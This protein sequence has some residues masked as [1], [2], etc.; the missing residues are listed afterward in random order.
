M[1]SFHLLSLLTWTSSDVE[2]ES[3]SWS[4]IKERS[5]SSDTFSFTS[6]QLTSR[7]MQNIG[8]IHNL[9]IISQSENSYVVTRSLCICILLHQNLTCL[10]L[11]TSTVASKVRQI[12]HNFWCQRFDFN[13][14]TAVFG[15]HLPQCC[16]TAKC[17]WL[18]AF[19]Q[20]QTCA[21]AKQFQFHPHWKENWLGVYSAFKEIYSC[22]TSA[23][24]RNHSYSTLTRR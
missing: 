3:F 2:I 21:I 23:G 16:V 19:Y 6:E 10:I 15:C 4:R 5:K 17:K 20:L 8:W 12:R 9:F 13:F 14:P 1:S 7:S 18:K 22:S 24:R 11:L